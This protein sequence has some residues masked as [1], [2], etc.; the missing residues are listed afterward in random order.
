MF[1]PHQSMYF[2]VVLIQK[3]ILS[4]VAAGAAPSCAEGTAAVGTPNVALLAALRVLLGVASLAEAQLTM[5]GSIAF[6]S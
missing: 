3:L 1:G 5:T 2:M 4:C 6:P